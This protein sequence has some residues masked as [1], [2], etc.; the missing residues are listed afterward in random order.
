[1]YKNCLL[2]NCQLGEPKQH[3]NNQMSDTDSIELLV[4]LQRTLLIGW[5]DC[6]MLN[7]LVT[8]CQCQQHS[9]EMTSL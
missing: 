4:K 3:M 6:K 9:F 2:R 8:M 5:Q 7:K 1:M